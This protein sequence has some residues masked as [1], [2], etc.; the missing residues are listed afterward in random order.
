MGDEVTSKTSNMSN[1]GSTVPCFSIQIGFVR[2]TFSI[3]DEAGERRSAIIKEKV[4]DMVRKRFPEHDF[5]GVYD[6]ILLF[7]HTPGESYVLQPITYASEIPDGSLVEAVLSATATVEDRQIRPH[8][9]YVHSYKSPTFCDFCGQMLFGLVRQG[10]K[11]H[12]CGGN[13]HKRC[14]FK[15]PNDCTLSKRRPSSIAYSSASLPWSTSEMSLASDTSDPMSMLLSKA[16]SYSKR[17]PSCGGRPLWVEKAVASRIKVPHTFV[18]HSYTKPTI[19][20]YCRKL[21]VGLFRQGIQCKDCKFNCHKRCAEKVPKDCLGEAP[22]HERESEDQEK[23]NESDENEPEENDA[24]TNRDSLGDTQDEDV[25]PEADS[26]PGPDNPLSPVQSNNIPL[27]RIVQ[28][29]KHTKRR[30]SQVLKEGW[31]VHCTDKDSMRKRHFWRIDTKSITLYQSDSSTRYYKEIPLSEILAVKTGSSDEEKSS[32]CFEIKTART[33]YFVGEKKEVA[34][35]TLTVDGEESPTESGIG[36]EVAKIWEKKIRQALMPVTP[37][38]S[39]TS[40]TSSSS[41]MEVSS[42]ECTCNSRPAHCHAHHTHHASSATSTNSSSIPHNV[43]YAAASTGVGTVG[44]SIPHHHRYMV[45]HQLSPPEESP[46]AVSQPTPPKRAG[47]AANKP[48]E[49]YKG[50]TPHKRTSEGSYTAIGSGATNENGE[51]LILDETVRHEKND[52]SQHYQI[53]P[54]E[55]LGSGQFGIVYG[56]VHRTS[57]RQVAIK[58]IDKLRFP[59]K[60]ETQLK[61][62]VSI[63][64]KVRHH[65]VV[66]LERMFETPERVFVVMEKLK[67]DMLEMILSSVNGRLDERVTRFLISQILIALKYLH[68]KNVVHCDLKPEN[69]LLSS[70][71]D[72]PQVKLCDFG[73]ARIIG[74]KSFRRSVVGTPAYLAPEVLRSK[75]Y[76]RSLDMWSVGVI[77]YVSLS[78]TFPF[79]EDE[80]ITDQIHNAAFMFPPNPWNE[81]SANAI[82][83]IGNL[84]QVKLRKRYTADKSLAHPWLQ[85]YQTWLDLRELESQVGER[86]LTHESDDERWEEY[87]RDHIEGANRRSPNH[88]PVN[89]SPIH[90]SPGRHMERVSTL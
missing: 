53:F 14:A 71:G 41:P 83:L 17:S 55:I 57:A 38:Q 49:K 2:E 73:F 35:A 79:N 5:Y 16:D 82:N 84:L 13:Y 72:F 45:M 25:G 78:G 56:G 69:V 39:T 19:C 58:V 31:M 59:T 77:I 11:C 18:V 74:E 3:P 42:G 12:G 80:E 4:N 37:Q 86:Y 87:R 63:L 68:I 23:L 9:L 85:D 1:A 64:H 33:I 34:M 28:S 62:E 21:L 81:I 75:G 32:H 50:Y 24:S 60:Q 6:K 29:V 52:I 15:I 46:G 61:N 76:N 44:P 89:E 47:S 48:T 65:G 30:S 36:I 90:L 10:L 20:Q 51:H 67:G 43:S 22:L 8:T 54:D 88:E 70:E 66:N 26:P 40:V 7:K 27:M